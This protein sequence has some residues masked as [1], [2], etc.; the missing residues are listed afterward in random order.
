MSVGLIFAVLMQVMLQGEVR[1]PSAELQSE[2]E[3]RLVE[4]ID[5]YRSGQIIE[6]YEA[7]HQIVAEGGQAP[8]LFF[9]LGVASNRMGRLGES[10]GWFVLASE[11]PRLETEA[12]DAY[13]SVQEQVPFTIPVLPKTPWQRSY[14]TIQG[15]FTPDG[16]SWVLSIGLYIVVLGLGLRWFTALPWRYDVSISGLGAVMA[17]F[18]S[19]MLWSGAAQYADTVKGFV[20]AES[21]RLYDDPNEEL[22][23][24]TTAYEGVEFQLRMSAL[25]TYA[26]T[27]SSESNDE[28]IVMDSTFP[29]P[30]WLPVTLSNGSSGWLQSED[31]FLADTRYLGSL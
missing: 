21:V 29:I 12:L 26:L 18:A 10:M 4:A 11:D 30:D 23:S 22:P 7:L 15:A 5:A 28:N 13:N 1:D 27:Q 16:W 24:E 19:I 25:K 9:N 3:A 20:T 6:S 31:V 2:H 14:D 17:L 8:E